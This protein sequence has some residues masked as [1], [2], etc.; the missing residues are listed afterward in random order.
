M[1][2]RIIRFDKY[3]GLVYKSGWYQDASKRWWANLS[4]LFGSIFFFYLIFLSWCGLFLD[5]FF[6]SSVLI[7][8]GP[9]WNTEAWLWPVSQPQAGQWCCGSIQN[10]PGEDGQADWVEGVREQAGLVIYMYM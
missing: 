9:F 3:G 4:H 7:I 6:G 8:L 10:I 2:D 5:V 1:H